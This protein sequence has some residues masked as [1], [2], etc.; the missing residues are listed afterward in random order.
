V[1]AAE[2]P[3]GRA[4][5]MFVTLT[6]DYPGELGYQSALA[7]LLNN[8]AVALAEVGRHER[9]A[10]VYEAAV[11]AQQRCWQQSPGSELMQEIL[12][13]MVYNQGRSLAALGAWERAAEAAIERREIWQ[14]RG[15]R[16]F[17][18]AVELAALRQA[19]DDGQADADVLA[20]LDRETISTLRQA[21][22]NG[23]PR[24]PELA[25]DERFAPLLGNEQFR[26]LVGNATN[27][28]PTT[29]PK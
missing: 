11:K 14:N 6:S 25:H 18:V 12:S 28:R 24:D 2:E 7:G 27:P 21:I 4:Q 23:Y 20:T 19:A 8:Q 22:E 15:E 9:A 13:R 10:K 1:D 3:F 5:E 16:L 26:A 17:G 29:K